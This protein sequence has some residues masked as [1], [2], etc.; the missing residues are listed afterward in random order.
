[1]V[2]VRHM[3]EELVVSGDTVGRATETLSASNNRLIS[4]M[5]RFKI[6]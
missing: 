5:R 4:M 1:M 2:A 6:S 3:V